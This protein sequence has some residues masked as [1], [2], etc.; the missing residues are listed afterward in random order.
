MPHC[1][2]SKGSKDNKFCS[3]NAFNQYAPNKVIEPIHLDINLQFEE[4]TKKTLKGKVTLTFKHTGKALISNKNDLSTTVL[5]AEEFE[6]V[7]VTSVDGE[8][9]SYRYDGHLIHLQWETPF[10]ANAERKVLIEYDI[11]DPIAGL[12]FQQEE[13]SSHWAVTDHETEKARYWLPTVDYPTVRT[14]LTWTIT[15]PEKYSSLANGSLLETTTVNGLTSTRWE[16]TY[17]CPSYLICFAV[18]DFIS[19]DDEEVNGIPIKYFTSTK[20]K[21]EDL[22]RT[23]DKTP[24]MIKWIQKKVGVSFP[25]TK[26]Y[27]IALPPSRGAMENISLVTWGD[28]FVMDEVYALERKPFADVV[29]IHEMAHTYFGDLLVIRHFEHAWLKESWATYMESCWIEDHLSKEDFDYDL[30]SNAQGYFG[31][32]ERYMRP[33]VT[34]KYDSSWD[35]FDSHIYPGGGWRIHMLRRLLGED[36]FWTGVKHYVEKYS[37]KT[38]QTTDFQNCLEEASGLNLTRFFDE[39]IYSKGYP[40]L[41]GTYEYD[42]KANVVKVTLTQ[43]QVD[44]DSQIPLF[45]FDVDIELTTSEKKTETVTVTFDRED[46]V[47][48]I[49]ALPKDVKPAAIRIDPENKVL[50]TLDMSAEQDILIETA[51]NAK[52]IVN[53]IWAYSELINKATRPALKA[54][55][56]LIKEEPFYGVRVRV[57]GKLAKLNSTLS[58][59]ILADMLTAEKHPLALAPIAAQ[60]KAQDDRLRQ[61]LISFLQRENLPYIA[62]GS[63]LTSLGSQRNKDDLSYLI[64]VAQDDSKI[65]QHALVRSGALT[66]LGK[67]RSKKAFEYLLERVESD[68]EPLRAKPFIIRALVESSPWQEELLQKQVNEILLKLIRHFDRQV[69][70]A[71]VV[72]LVNLKDK[73]AYEAIESTRC[74]YA[75]DDQSWMNRQLEKLKNIKSAGEEVSKELIEKLEERVKKL[76]DELYAIKVENEVN[77]KKSEQETQ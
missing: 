66:A 10:T 67:H 70:S 41:K 54:V 48:A 56:E 27:Q 34:R 39:W 74:M 60:C 58:I 31:E 47:T 50:F 71:A 17:P 1:C 72:G 30:F 23:F 45:A 55:R 57:A 2:Y 73:S 12:Y 52:D 9:I 16:L 8:N 4:L 21:A 76:E 53:R 24:S 38:V 20:Y 61:A 26:Y 35:M 51:K 63:A 49:I 46:K 77:S 28:N 40:K 32:C 75:K 3:S 18:G 19:V 68:K 36:A 37:C 15:A 7:K 6:N 5:N 62:H 14:T 29:N 25:W 59:D 22:K 11:E 44:A 13:G 65:G 69:R 43:T 64:Q 33:I 42:M